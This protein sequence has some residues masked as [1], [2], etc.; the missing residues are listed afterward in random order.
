[1]AGR[2]TGYSDFYKNAPANQTPSGRSGATPGKPGY[3]VPET[4]DNGDDKAA[5]I[6]RR[7]KRTSAAMRAKASR[8]TG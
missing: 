1:M 3:G 8:R 7:L 6:K 2:A 4:P 5:A